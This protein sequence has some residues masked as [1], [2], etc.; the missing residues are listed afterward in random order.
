MSEIDE[1]KIILVTGVT[2]F[3]GRQVIKILINQRRKISI[4]V[5]NEKKDLIPHS[6]YIESVV[7]SDDMFSENLD[8]WA[9]VCKGI[10]TVIH[11]AWYVEPQKYY[12]SEKN[13]DCLIGSLNLLK[14]AKESQVR[15]LVFIGTCS[16][17]QYCDSKLTPDSPL[18]SSSLYEG[19]KIALFNVLSHY[20]P[21][22]HIEFAW[23]RLF[24]LYGEGE[25]RRRFVSY[26][27]SQLTAG[28]IAELSEGNQVR[29]YLDVKKAADMIVKISLSDFQGAVNICSGVPITIRQFAESIADE[30]GR[31]ELLRFGARPHNLVDPNY[32]VGELSDFFNTN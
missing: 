11:V 10:D 25:D 7:I 6:Q 19:S 27:Q 12:N 16:E 1:N 30:Y 20:A 26:L 5:R 2:G 29:D 22:H 28:E 8:W 23:C 14:G 21:S 3:V 17:Y 13:I 4:I 9:D 15:R 32:V 18:M 24:Y 31:R